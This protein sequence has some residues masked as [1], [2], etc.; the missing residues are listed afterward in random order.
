MLSVLQSAMWTA[1]KRF[2]YADW[3]RNL[4]PMLRQATLYEHTLI[5]QRD[6]QTHC[7]ISG[8]SYS[9]YKSEAL[10][11]VMGY[12]CLL[13]RSQRY[14]DQSDGHFPL[15]RVKCTVNYD[16]IGCLFLQFFLHQF[17]DTCYHIGLYKVCILWGTSLW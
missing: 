14:W 8:C 11:P 13:W 17:F 7:K 3:R 12:R 16:L 2:F 10:A 5:A 6:F 9:S 1:P 15:L 4:R